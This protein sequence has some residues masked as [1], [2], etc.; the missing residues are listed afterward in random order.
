M[1]KIYND[2]NGKSLEGFNRLKQWKKKIKV[3]ELEDKSF[4]I[5]KFEERKE[6]WTKV[7]IEGGRMVE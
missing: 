4:E 2:C 5:I 1:L 7:N 6:I 3:H